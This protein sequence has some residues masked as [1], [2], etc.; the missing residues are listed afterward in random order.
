MDIPRAA[1]AM[2]AE[3]AGRGLD[4]QR[5][6]WTDADVIFSGDWHYPREAPLPTFAAGSEVFSS[7]LNSGVIYGNVSVSRS[8][9]C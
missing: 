5:I 9:R 4:P 6:L 2:Q 7:S 3:L 8:P 1:H